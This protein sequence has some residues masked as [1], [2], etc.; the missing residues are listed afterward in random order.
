MLFGLFFFVGQ[1]DIHMVVEV[2]CGSNNEHHKGTCI[3][4]IELLYLQTLVTLPTYESLDNLSNE[5]DLYL[6][7][8]S[9]ETNV[10]HNNQ[11]FIH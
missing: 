7:I 2:R 3:K 5:N 1:L 4:A 6:V 10:I 11:Y 9:S 8:S